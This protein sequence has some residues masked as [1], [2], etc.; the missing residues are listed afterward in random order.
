MI[1]DSYYILDFGTLDGTAQL[2]DGVFWHEASGKVLFFNA[3]SK[4]VYINDAGD[5][6]E[7]IL[8]TYLCY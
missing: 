6:L 2:N 4:L 7:K 8:D 3:T 1:L 5:I